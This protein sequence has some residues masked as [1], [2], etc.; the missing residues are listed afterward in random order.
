MGSSP[1]AGSEAELHRAHGGAPRRGRQHAPASVGEEDGV[2]Q[3]RF[4]ARELRHESDDEFLAGQTATQG[5]EGFVGGG[6]GDVL[7][8]EKPAVLV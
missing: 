7:F 3:F 2:D 5:V 1:S 8:A 6:V 4:T